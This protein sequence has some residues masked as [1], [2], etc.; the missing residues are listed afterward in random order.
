MCFYV[1]HVKG[2][3]E[4]TSKTLFRLPKTLSPHSIWFDK[5]TIECM[6]R[7]L[8]KLPLWWI[9]YLNSMIIQYFVSTFPIILWFM[10]DLIDLYLFFLLFLLRKNG[11]NTPSHHSKVGSIEWKSIINYPH[12]YKFNLVIR[13]SREEREER[14]WL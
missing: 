13:F 4:A 10:R 9:M 14:F 5:F 8:Q 11:P 6:Y 12:G 1:R 2:I 3:V 7:R